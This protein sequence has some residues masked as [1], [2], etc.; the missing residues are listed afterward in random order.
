MSKELIKIDGQRGISAT[1]WDLT[2][3]TEKQWTEAGQV[4]V[5]VDQA[6]QWWLGDWWNAC[7]W[8]DGKKACGDLGVNWKTA[9]NAGGVCKAFQSARR[10][11]LL[12]FSH[13]I[14]IMGL[15]V[16][17]EDETGEKIVNDGKTIEMQE[18]FLNLAESEL[19]T[20]KFTNQKVQEYMAMAD[21]TESEKERRFDAESGKAVVA[22]INKDGD[23]NL[24]N[25][26]KQNGIYVFIG[27][28]QFDIGWGNPFDEKDGTRNEACDAHIRY[29][30]DKKGLHGKL[31][32]L[33]GKVLGCY[34]Y[35]NRCHG[36][37][38]ATLANGEEN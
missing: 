19:W 36:D 20:V 17:S 1:G 31:A 23:V 3:I 35:P 37:H 28:S 2:N 32:D 8:G 29:F 15:K 26:A 16:L 6:R 13:H 30:K 11:A 7:Q 33:E 12:T 14:S 21:W 24:V 10:R 22:N 34:C 5:K 18:K 25:W 38:L 9:H 4:L 27:R